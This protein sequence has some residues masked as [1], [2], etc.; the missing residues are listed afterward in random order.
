VNVKK[1]YIVPS[2]LSADFSKLGDEIRKVESAGADGIHLDVMDGHFVPNLTIGPAVVRSIR[3]VSRLP[4]W[5]HL[6]IEKP[7]QYIEPFCRAG[8]DGI[9]IHPETGENMAELLDRIH[10]LGK[11]AGIAVNPETRPDMIPRLSGKIDRVLVMTVHPGFGGQRLMPD[12]LD[13]IRNLRQ[14]LRDDQLIEVDGGVNEKTAS[15]VIRSGADVLIAGDAIFA[16]PD[17]AKA[18]K[19]LR[20]IAENSIP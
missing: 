5:A 19:A 16:K 10:A 9:F 1:V 6:M 2:I 20:Q 8:A 11:Q 12:Q 15:D 7:D 17:P 14:L 13:K 18:L 3:G 4:Y